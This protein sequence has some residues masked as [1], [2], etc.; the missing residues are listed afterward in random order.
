[1]DNS[2]QTTLTFTNKMLLAMII[3]AS[4]NGELLEGILRHEWGFD[5][6]VTTDWGIKNDPIAEVKAG[7]DLKMPTGYPEELEAALADGTLTRGDLEN[8]VSRILHTYQKIH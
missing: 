4:E 2:S 5:S 1:M 6:M 7:N 8:C 3:H